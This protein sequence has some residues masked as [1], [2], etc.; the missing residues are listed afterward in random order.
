VNQASSN[1]LGIAQVA[2]ST[3]PIELTANS[4]RA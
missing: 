4:C 3:G 1:K 2:S